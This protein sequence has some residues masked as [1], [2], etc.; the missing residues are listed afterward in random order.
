M[1][2]EKTA[3]IIVT[4]PFPGHLKAEERKEDPKNVEKNSREGERGKWTEILDW[5]GVAAADKKKRWRRSVDAL[6]VTKRI[7]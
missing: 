4:Q 1:S 7:G 5:G 6:S 3:E 2:S